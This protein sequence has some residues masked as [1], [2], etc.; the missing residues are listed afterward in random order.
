M[1]DIKDC[2]THLCL[3]EYAG[4]GPSALSAGKRIRLLTSLTSKIVRDKYDYS[5]T[6]EAKD[7]LQRFSVVASKI[8]VANI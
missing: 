5:H 6:F 7:S 3:M 1:A 2:V 8:Y 4:T